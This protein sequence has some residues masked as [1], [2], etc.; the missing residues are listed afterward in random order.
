M[1]NFQIN[2]V[3]TGGQLFPLNANKAQLS[4]L[5]AAAYDDGLDQVFL[6]DGEQVYLLEGDGLD[7]SGLK[8]GAHFFDLQREGQPV[9]LTVL[10]FDN[11]TNTAWEGAKATAK[12]AAALVGLGTA[13]GGTLGA[14]GLRQSL[15]GSAL[16]HS[17]AQGLKV[18]LGKSSQQLMLTQI[19]ASGLQQSLKNHA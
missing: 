4:D 1:S 7:L 16:M 11:E 17:S 10:A 2:G 8:K 9:T 5:Q 19:G 15:A 6:A 3:P 13:A 14:L 12:G 18:A